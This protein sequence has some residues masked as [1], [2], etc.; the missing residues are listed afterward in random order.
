MEK[1]GKRGNFHCTNEKKNIIFGKKG[2]GAT[3]SY[4]G[5]PAGCEAIKVF[6]KQ[7][8]VCRSTLSNLNST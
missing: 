7:L 3:I 2:G 5:I 8:K 6:T 1:W 4:L